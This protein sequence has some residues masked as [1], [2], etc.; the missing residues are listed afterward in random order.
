MLNHWLHPSRFV[1]ATIFAFVFAFI[2]WIV[3]M[4]Y[5]RYFDQTNYYTVLQ[6]VSVDKNTYKPCEKTTI[7]TTR[8]ALVD[9]EISYTRYL[10]LIRIGDNAQIIIDEATN[11]SNVGVKKGIA[12]VSKSLKLPCNLEDGR[13]LWQGVATYEYKNSKK[14]YVYI[15]EVFAV[16]KSGIP[17]N[18]EDFLR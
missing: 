1:N 8:T 11:K 17:K 13:Y 14:T 6:P 15:S 3:P 10:R 2:G 12:I 16:R 4:T 9:L 7:T 5:F 18:T